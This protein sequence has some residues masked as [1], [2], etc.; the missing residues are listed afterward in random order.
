M[1]RRVHLEVGSNV[2]RNILLTLKMEV[3]HLGEISVTSYKTTW[4]DNP[5]DHNGRRNVGLCHYLYSWS[6]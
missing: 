1:L 6:C 3:L 5:E 4:C 2:R